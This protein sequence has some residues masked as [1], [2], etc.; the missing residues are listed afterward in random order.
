MTLSERSHAAAAHGDV[1]DAAVARAADVGLRVHGER[2]PP[3]RRDLP[4]GHVHERAL[5]QRGVRDRARV[6]ARVP[7]APEAVH[8]QVGELDERVVVELGGQQLVELPEGPLELRVVVARLDA[9]GRASRRRADR[10]ERHL[11]LEE[12][13]KRQLRGLDLRVRQLDAE[14]DRAGRGG[15]R[16][17]AWRPR[18]GGG[19]GGRA[20]SARRASRS[21]CRGRPRTAARPAPRPTARASAAP[22]AR[23]ATDRSPPT[24]SRRGRGR[25]CGRERQTRVVVAIVYQPSSCS[26]PNGPWSSRSGDGRP[27]AEVVA[28]PE[29]G[30]NVRSGERGAHRCERRTRLQELPPV[31]HRSPLWLGRLNSRPDPSADAVVRERDA[32]AGGDH[33]EVARADRREVAER[34]GGRPTSPA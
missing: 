34:R 14:R 26:I 1:E 31:G 6:V 17:R 21:G 13:G 18:P 22:R 16:R 33:V 28:L 30:A 20:G 7:L 24:R 9:I 12:V 25:D 10:D 27:G 3:P 19:R 23:R 32:L 2:H 15:A 4:L 8:H 5:G 29:V 11:R